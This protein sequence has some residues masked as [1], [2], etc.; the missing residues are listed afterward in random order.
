[1]FRLFRSH[2]MLSFALFFALT[3]CSSAPSAPSGAADTASADK[4]AQQEEHKASRPIIIATTQDAQGDRL[5]AASYNGSRHVH[6]SVYEALVDYQGGGKLAPSLAES[7]EATPDGTTYT[8][9]LRKGVQFSDGSA[10]TA[11]AVKFSLERAAA[12]KDTA[13]LELVRKLQSIDTPDDYTV[14]I[15]FKEMASQILLELS[16]A[17]PLRIMSPNAVSPAGAVDGEFKQAIGTGPWKITSYKKDVETVLAPNEHYWREKPSTHNLVL[18]VITD[19]Q[20]RVLA[21][22]NGEADIAGGELGNIPLEN[23]PLFENN[24]D[25]IIEQHPSTMSYFMVINQ[26]QE[27]L[28]DRN[29]RQAINLGKD[30]SVLMNGQGAEVK[31]LFQPS[32]AFVTDNNQPFY[33]YHPDQ[34]KQLLEKSG[35]VWNNN[36]QLYE[37]NGK[38]LALRLVIQTEEYPEWKEMAEIFQDQMKKIGIRIDILNQERAS[39]Y[40]TLWDTKEYDLLLYRTYTDAQLPYRFL[41][42][43]FYDTKETPAVA[44]QD[45]QLT[46]YLDQI[47]NT[48][49][50]PEQQAIFDKLFTRM[51]E[52]AMTVP[53]YY[54]RQTFV[55]SSKIKGFTFASIED[56]PVKWHLLTA[57][58]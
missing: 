58:E 16:Q 27:F 18:K 53:M 2:L 19:P 49:S 44:Y 47:A 36:K 8:F 6:A 35:F 26:H 34:A 10:L 54:T 39:Y 56:D 21:L 7:W 22:Q 28:A 50:E 3:A 17:R 32:V 38:E 43:L 13:P 33:G 46:E 25:F 51:H 31:G 24:K 45:K 15:H 12:N 5:D 20:A 29:V 52:E 1:M 57:G 23:L 9:H 14:I 11:G 42:S 30:S 55:H 41:S 37:K 4:P 48:I 40:N